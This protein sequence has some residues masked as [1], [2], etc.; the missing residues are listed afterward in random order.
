MSKCKQFIAKWR[1]LFTMA[2]P[3]SLFTYLQ[4]NW[5]G[6]PVF[7]FESIYFLKTKQENLKW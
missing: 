3:L 7:C 1:A 4:I 5:N 2:S 6:K